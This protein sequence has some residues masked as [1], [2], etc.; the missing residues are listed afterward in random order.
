MPKAQARR[1]VALT[2]LLDDAADTLLLQLL[3]HKKDKQS[4]ES[5]FFP[6][7]NALLGDG[8]ANAWHTTTKKLSTNCLNERA[9]NVETLVVWI[10]RKKM[11][12]SPRT[13]IR[14]FDKSVWMVS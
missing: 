5:L 3:E 7:A 4:S 11:N 2:V 12:E 9:P 6:K 10:Y 14:C 8:N 1:A 13:I